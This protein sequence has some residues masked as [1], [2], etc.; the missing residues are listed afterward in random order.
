[1][2][3]HEKDEI[4]EYIRVEGTD[5]FF[6]CDV[7]DESVTEL[8]QTL[9]KVENETR[10]GLAKLGLYNQKPQITV[11]IRSDGGDLYAGLAAMDFMKAMTAHVTTVAEGCVASASTLIFLGGD[12]RR[13]ERNAYILIHQIGSEFWGKFEQLKDEMRQCEKLMRHL[14][15]LYMRET[16]IPEHKLDK[17]LKRDLYLSHKKC[18]KYGITLP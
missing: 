1:M 2:S 6:Y 14:K 11:H 5:I 7:H 13:V 15:R 4:N 3:D 12:T 17:M 18:D 9:K 16:N 10:V 8:I